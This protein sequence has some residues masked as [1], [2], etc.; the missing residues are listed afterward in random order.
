[1]GIAA[2]VGVL[3]QFLDEAIFGTLEDEAAQ[4]EKE[5]LH[6]SLDTVKEKLEQGDTDMTELLVGLCVWY[7]L[8]RKTLAEIEKVARLIK[9]PTMPKSPL[10]SQ[11]QKVL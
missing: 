2:A 6:Q 3:T 8:S 1:M 7:Q 4:Q 11:I 5:K 10:L 9:K